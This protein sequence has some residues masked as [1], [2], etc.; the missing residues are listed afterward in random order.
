MSKK[1]ARKSSDQPQRAEPRPP[2]R[3]YLITPRLASAEA[4]APSLEAALEAADCACVLLRPASGA[5][6]AIGELLAVVRPI[7][8]RH[9]T[10]LLI[11]SDPATAKAAQVDGCH[12]GPG[13]ASL[14]DALSLLKPD[15]IVGVGGIR[16]RHDAMTAGETDVDYLMFGE[17]AADGWTPPVDETLE[18][19]GWWA[20][21]FTVPC[22]AFAA[23]LEAV[24]P[25]AAAGADFVALGDALWN[26]PRGPAQAA[27]AAM[28]AMRAAVG[29]A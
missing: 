14:P 6:D 20:E 2:P 8:E 24:G 27:R 17:P 25:L 13:G 9:D 23:S 5:A 3:L 22:V 18:W 28:E 11:E 1:R 26:D 4:F 29:L 7:V 16:K 15:G 10:A 21:I 12:M 19:V